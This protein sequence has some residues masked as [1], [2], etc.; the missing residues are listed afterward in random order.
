MQINFA[1][2]EDDRKRK[3]RLPLPNKRLRPADCS[4]PF[5]GVAA[6]ISGVGV[7]PAAIAASSGLPPGSIIATCNADTGRSRGSFS[8]QRKNHLFNKRV[9]VFNNF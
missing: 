8:R 4:A 6:T 1:G 3:E 5:F 9:N 7:S 2:R